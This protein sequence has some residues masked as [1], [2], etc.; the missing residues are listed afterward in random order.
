[1]AKVTRADEEVSI[2]T[3]VGDELSQADIDALAEEAEAGY[4][5]S[6]AKTERVGRPSLED[7]IS[8]R[9]SFRIGQGLYEAA[10]TRAEHEGRTVSELAR[11]AMERYLRER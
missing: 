11:E 1:M 10:R 6:T 8:P 2:R 7:G 9:V 3:S 5:L 4:D